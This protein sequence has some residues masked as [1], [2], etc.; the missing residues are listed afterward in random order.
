M[1]NSTLATIN[2]ELTGPLHECGRR[3]LVNS[4][5]VRK[6]QV[7]RGRQHKPPI[8]L[9]LRVHLFPERQTSDDRR[10]VALTTLQEEKKIL[11]GEK[12]N[13]NNKSFIFLIEDDSKFHSNVE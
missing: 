12:K 8:K 3:L 13:K 9:S 2:T 1:I 7:Q 10:L 6:H 5:T 11:E 4:K